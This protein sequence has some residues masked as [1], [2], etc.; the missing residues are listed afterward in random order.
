MPRIETAMLTTIACNR[1]ARKTFA[2]TRRVRVRKFR[3]RSDSENVDVR[4]ALS[5][6]MRK[7]GAAML[8]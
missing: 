6:S 3:D 7:R 5:F 4:F 8:L 2:G 1:D